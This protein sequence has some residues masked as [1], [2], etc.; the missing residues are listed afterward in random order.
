MPDAA[1]EIS[2]KTF[3]CEDNVVNLKTMR[4][5]FNDPEVATLTLDLVDTRYVWPI[6]LDGQYRISPEGA[7]M[8]GYWKDSQTFLLETFDIGIVNR[9]MEVDG[10]RLQFS[11]P[12]A[13]L[14]VTCQAQEP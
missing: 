8:R 9:Q 11:L 4:L 6:G 5:D 13:G 12:D 2:G 10:N 7:G 3:Q 14:T 1:R